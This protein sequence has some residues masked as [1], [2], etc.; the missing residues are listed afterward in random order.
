M[1]CHI[2]DLVY[3][4]LMT[5][6]VCDMEFENTK[7]QCIL[8]R[9]LNAIVKKK[10]LGMPISKGSWRIVHKQIGM[11]FTLFMGLEILRSRWLIKNIHVF[12]IRFSLWIDKPSN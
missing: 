7:V 10:G 11:F 9:K 6:A 4:K 8:W 3:C 1:A 5:I 2:Y 12:S